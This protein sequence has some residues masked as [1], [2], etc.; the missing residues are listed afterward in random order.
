MHKL[1]IPFRFRER[2]SRSSPE[3]F[4]FLGRT[5][6]HDLVAITD[7]MVPTTSRTLLPDRSPDRAST[8]VMRAKLICPQL[9]SPSPSLANGTNYTDLTTRYHHVRPE[10]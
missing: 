2:R 9:H 10:H 5:E 4:L 8:S 3:L 6:Q 1:G 7:W